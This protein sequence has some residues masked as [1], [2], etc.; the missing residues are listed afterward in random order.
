[1]MNGYPMFTRNMMS[2][3]PDGLLVIEIG[4]GFA[5]SAYFSA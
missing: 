1:M 3:H 4:F 2:D 5:V